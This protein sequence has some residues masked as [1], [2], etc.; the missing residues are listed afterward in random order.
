MDQD[1]VG[2]RGL[3]GTRS[4]QRLVLTEPRD[5]RLGARHDDEVRIAA[6]R[7]R[8][9]DLAL[10]LFCADHVLPAAGDQAGDLGEALVL[11][12]DRAHAGTFVLLHGIEDVDGIAE[13]G[14]DVGHHRQ[15]GAIDDG[16]RH[17]EMLGHRHD[18]DI[19]HAVHRGKLEAR[20]PDRVEAGLRSQ[21]RRQRAMRRH[22]L[23]D[24]LV[25]HDLPQPGACSHDPP[26]PRR[27]AFSNSAR[28]RAHASISLRTP[29]RCFSASGSS[30]QRSTW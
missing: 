13:A 25:G 17:V 19:R 21:H 6:G 3:I 22:R 23:G 11:H 1:Q 28:K 7:A 27:R 5:Q 8:R 9:L 10:E 14:V 12:H 18:A 30:P 15:A 2:A 4:L 20:R 16:P 29:S 24:S 26:Q